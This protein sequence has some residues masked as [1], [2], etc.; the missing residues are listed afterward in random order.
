MPFPKND[1]V[2]HAASRPKRDREHIALSIKK[3]QPYLF[4]AA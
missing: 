1:I 2:F 4:E 3:I